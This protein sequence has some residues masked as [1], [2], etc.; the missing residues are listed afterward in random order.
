M[1]PFLFFGEIIDP[2]EHLCD[3]LARYARYIYC[4]FGVIAR[5]FTGCFSG[6]A[7]FVVKKFL[8]MGFQLAPRL[9][10]DAMVFP[11]QSTG[12]IGATRPDLHGE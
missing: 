7:V 1:V 12:Y 2:L 3:M 6:G 11:V 5:R 4:D 9:V 8:D 10:A